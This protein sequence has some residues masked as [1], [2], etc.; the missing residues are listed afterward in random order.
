MYALKATSQLSSIECLPL[1]SQRDIPEIDYDKLR[2][3]RRDVPKVEGLV[4]R[5]FATGYGPE[6][7][8]KDK[9]ESDS[10]VGSIIN[11]SEQDASEEVKR[12]DKRP[13]VAETSEESTESSTKKRKKERRIKRRRVRKKRRVKNG[14]TRSNQRNKKKEARVL[15]LSHINS[16]SSASEF[17]L[18]FSLHL[19]LLLFENLDNAFI[20]YYFIGTPF[21]FQSVHCLRF[22]FLFHEIT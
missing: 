8:E 15:C 20:F 3:P 17:F 16:L 2:V 5:H 18:Y 4:V 14:K 6:E 13:L 1:V 22:C 21:F 7:K 10:K 19:L 11:K 12:S 9:E